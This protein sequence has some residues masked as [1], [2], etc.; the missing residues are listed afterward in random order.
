M[1]FLAEDQLVL[2]VQLHLQVHK[3]AD[4]TGREWLWFLL[5]IHTLFSVLVIVVIA[6]LDLLRFWSIK[7][8]EI[9]I[10]VGTKQGRISTQHMLRCMPVHICVFLLPISDAALLYSL[11]P[12]FPCEKK[13]LL[14]IFRSKCSKTYFLSCHF[15]KYD[16]QACSAKPFFVTVCKFK[17]HTMPVWPS[18]W[19]IGEWSKIITQ[20]TPKC[21]ICFTKHPPNYP[22]KSKDQNMILWCPP[23]LHHSL[24]SCF[25][26]FITS[27]T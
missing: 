9:R 27:I 3:A 25:A 7:S 2:D 17:N 21:Q 12:A 22:S 16:K 23:Y 19:L 20:M 14:W 24:S 8:A 10:Q 5:N 4:A 18:Y 6:K 15:S 26:P 11:I 1:I 13:N